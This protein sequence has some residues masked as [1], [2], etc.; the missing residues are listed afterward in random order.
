[1]GCAL[2]CTAIAMDDTRPENSPILLE[3]QLVRLAEEMDASTI[4]TPRDQLQCVSRDATVS[5]AR[6]LMADMF[7]QLPVAH[8]DEVVAERIRPL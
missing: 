1:M 6:D 3:E 4:M 2:P 7:D 5:S 8:G